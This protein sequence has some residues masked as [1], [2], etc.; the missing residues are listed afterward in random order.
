MMNYGAKTPKRQYLYSNA[1]A[2]RQIDAGKLQRDPKKQK[3]QT[4]KQY[5]SANGKRAYCGTDKL[6]ATEHL[7]CFL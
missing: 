1:T 6:T 4:V 5:V 3:I 2:A 7:A